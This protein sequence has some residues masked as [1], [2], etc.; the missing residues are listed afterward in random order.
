[1]QIWPALLDLLMAKC[2][3]K[4]HIWPSL[5]EFIRGPNFPLLSKSLTEASEN[6][7]QLRIHY[8]T[9][10]NASKEFEN[11]FFISFSKLSK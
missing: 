4:K 6:T 2:S 1:M 5:I 10:L 9:F 8:P 7:H 3:N 11:S